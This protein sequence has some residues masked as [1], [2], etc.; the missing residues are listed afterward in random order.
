MGPGYWYYSGSYS[1]SQAIGP[2]HRRVGDLRKPPVDEVRPA[3]AGLLWLRFRGI[4][5]YLEAP[6]GLVSR[7]SNWP[8][9]PCVR[10]VLPLSCQELFLR[11][12]V[13]ISSW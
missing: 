1:T 3:A 13:S 9:R 6:G 4:R 10:L 12:F 8:Y 5:V 11:T 7:L 2:G